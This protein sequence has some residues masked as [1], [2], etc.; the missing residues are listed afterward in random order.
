MNKFSALFFVCCLL[1]A[2]C[3]K[4][5]ATPSSTPTPAPTPAS[6]FRTDY[7]GHYL[8][9]CSSSHMTLDSL[10]NIIWVNTVLDSV[11][12]NV[13]PYADSSL[14]FVVSGSSLILNYMSPT[15]YVGVGFPDWATFTAPDSLYIH[16]HSGA[17]NA[18]EYYGH[19][20]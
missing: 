2:S 8:C 6:D 10:G 5:V 16:Q 7:F 4:D 13:I 11:D 19:K 18:I 9:S 1:V 15:Q 3:T 17:A 20:L 14:K 12:V